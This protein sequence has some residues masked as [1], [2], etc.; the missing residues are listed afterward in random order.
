MDAQYKRQPVREIAFDPVLRR[1]YVLRNRVSQ[2]TEW[3]GTWTW[4]L[5]FGSSYVRTMALDQRNNRVL[6]VN[7]GE[8]IAEREEKIGRGLRAYDAGT[9]TATYVCRRAEWMFPSMICDSK[10]DHVIISSNGSTLTLLLGRDLSSI[11]TIDLFY[12]AAKP[13]HLNEMT[14]DYKTDRLICSDIHRL[15]IMSLEDFSVIHCVENYSGLGT[16]IG[17]V[18]G[19]C[20]DNKGRIVFA[21]RVLHTLHAFTSDGVWMSDF[22]LDHRVSAVAFDRVSGAFAHSSSDEYPASSEHP[23]QVEPRFIEPNTWLPGTFSWTLQTRVHTPEAM[24]RV[25]FMV[26]AIRGLVESPLSLIPNEL[27]FLIFECL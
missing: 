20:V 9:L 13:R 6:L 11:K 15:M 14:I 8:H 1:M 22:Q 4:V 12:L 23:L 24:R 17:C 16:E 25:M 3:N 10:R 7:D 2:Y 27:L 21:D 18:N 19:L 5:D 26:T